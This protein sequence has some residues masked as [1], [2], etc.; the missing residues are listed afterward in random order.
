MSRVLEQ[1][2]EVVFAD[3]R[4]HVRRCGRVAVFAVAVWGWDGVV[5]TDVDES[6]FVQFE[7]DEFDACEGTEGEECPP[8]G[9]YLVVVRA[10]GGKE[11]LVGVKVANAELEEF[12]GVDAFIVADEEEEWF[13][14]RRW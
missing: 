5:L 10:E 9:A 6:A 7:F 4:D 3:G 14:C 13:Y 8:A 2:H 12:L 1:V 11:L